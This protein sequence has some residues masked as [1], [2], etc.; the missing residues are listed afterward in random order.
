[1][2]DLT[3]APS[4][5]LKTLT[6]VARWSLWL[7]LMA[8]FVFLLTWGALH[9]LI[10]PRIGE[11]RPQLEGQASRVLGVPVRIGAITAHSTGMIPAFELTNVQLFDADG[12]EALRLP[13]V[14]AALSPRS[15][16]HLGFEQLY[17]DRPTLSIRRGLDGKILVAGLDFSKNGNSGKG[18]A[19]WF[20]SQIEFAIHE[21]TI[22]WTDEMRSAP[23][24]ALKQ[25]DL[26]VRNSGRRHDMR[27][28]ATPSGLWGERFSLQGM[29]RQPLLSGGSGQ[30]Q[31]WEGQLHAA[32]ARVDLSELRRYADIGIDLHQGNG[33]VNTW[34]DVSQGRVVGATADI[35]LKTLELQ[36]VR[37]RLGGR[38]LANG[39]EFSTQAL[40]FDTRDGLHWPGGNVSLIYLG[41]EGK[42]AA[43]G[44]LKADKLDLTALAQIADRLPI[45]AKARA[46]L[47][48]YAPKGLVERIQAS[49]QGNMGALDQYQVKGLV[50]QF[51]LAAQAAVAPA[52]VGTPGVRGA[53]VEFEFNQSSGKAGV[54]VADGALELPGVFDEPVVPITQLSAEV[55]WQINGEQLAV[56]LPNL[57]FSNVDA[58][59]EAQIKWQTS[60]AVTA[61]S[62]S[63]HPGVLD[64]QGSLN[65]ADGTRV[66]RYLPS[67][68][69]RSARDYVRDAVLAGSASGVKFKVKGD[70]ANMPF[71]D[72][73]QGEFSVSANVKNAT[74]LYVPGNIGP[75]GALPWPALTNL[76]GELVFQRAGMEV[77]GASAHMGSGVGLQ[78]GKVEALIPDLKHATVS[79]NAQLHGALTE[80]LAVV[81]GSPVGAMIGQALRRAVASG[82]ADYKLK[83]NLPIATIDRSTVQGSVTLPGN[84]IQ[85]TPDTPRLT[86][87]RGI[88]NFS[89]NGFSIAGGQA[90]MLGGDVRLEGGSVASSGAGANLTSPSVVIRASGAVSAEG[91]R[92]AKELGFVAR[93]AQHATGAAAYTAVLGFRRGEPELTVTSNLQ[94]LSLGLPAP[95]NKSAETVLPFRLETALVREPL[96]AVSGE[97]P[98]LRDQLTLVLGRLASIVYVRDL[99]SPEPRVIRGSMAVGLS[100]QE[101]APMPDDGVVANINLNAFDLDAW[102]AVLSQAAL[103]SLT[104]TGSSSAANAALTY[105]P[106]R[107]AVRARELTF[108][109]RKLNNVVVGGSR[110]GLLWRANL[111]ATELNGYLEYRQPS[112]TGEGRVYARLARL[113]IAPTA[114]S[115]VEALLNE[116]PASIPALDI[117]VE[118]FELRGKRLGRMEVQAINR[119]NSDASREGG[120]REWRLNRFNMITPEAVLTATGN[121]ASIDAQSGPMTGVPTATG[122][123]LRRRTV[124]NFKLD[125]SDA[126]ELLARFG[127]RDVVHKGRGK[128]EGQVA[129]VGSPLSLDYPSMSGAFGVTVE[130]GQFLKADPGIA[131]LLG[132]LSLQALPRRLTLDFRDVFSDGFSFDF[133]RGDVTVE[134]GIA[135][136]NNL[137]MKGVNAAV[138]MDGW[139]DI[140]KETQDVRVVVVPEINAGTAS[141]IASVINPAVGLGT[142]LAQL[143]FRRPL[144]EA[145]TQEFHVD[146]SWADPKITKVQRK[147]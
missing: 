67:I 126:G 107:M 42:M 72:P 49:W 23:A 5:L 18:A 139:A 125:I 68:I 116:Q 65:R 78:V 136:T 11:F 57:K 44:E 14:L 76:S 70:L 33:A 109:G 20:F 87:S 115:E 89:E 27:L 66:Y 50:S 132:V 102:S 52:T 103:T 138:L 61:R 124:L 114:A 100:P 81:N 36:S 77:R 15:L 64:L 48:A 120:V 74:L 35:A 131:K 45:D 4:P 58:Q 104:G 22:E 105:L 60:D 90:R 53:N 75:A 9:W 26:V 17:V 117:V 142:F 71:V 79:V 21:G 101:S 59:G 55:K 118:D 1:M 113:T 56:Q 84:D 80:A 69:P 30:W 2:I 46:A 13:R 140:A 110:D 130:A 98:G 96:P 93:M 51:E 134:Q 16:W 111:D 137:Q 25:V 12:R 47:L 85:I 28:D 147:L 62:P 112:G 37:G 127:M 32:F 91:L 73:R 82:S 6:S 92:Q 135:R 119:G 123:P 83:L 95:L 7:L 99:S 34:I 40:A 145:A 128:M 141:L 133:V 41:S 146:G 31:D 24:L 10:V 38:V 54:D 86:R 122:A 39:F 3:P 121:W 8:W 129:W 43:R 29:F 19:D 144:M 143:F 88:V 63:G 97:P 108:G 106:T 94:G